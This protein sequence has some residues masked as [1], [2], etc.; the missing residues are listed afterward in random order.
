MRWALVLALLLSSPCLP[1]CRS[2]RSEAGGTSKNF[3]A[4]LTNDEEDI[5]GAEPPE[6]LGGERDFCRNLRWHRGA[7]AHGTNS[8][9]RDR[10]L[11]VKISALSALAAGCVTCVRA[12]RWRFSAFASRWSVIGSGSG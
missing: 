10:T 9:Q 1:P 8:R 2:P 3:E 7:Q 4:T 6:A 12:V 11:S 5:R